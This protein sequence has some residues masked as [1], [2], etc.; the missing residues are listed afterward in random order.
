MFLSSGSGTLRDDSRRG[1]PQS[2][3]R[4]SPS[5]GSCDPSRRHIRIRDRRTRACDPR[6]LRG[7][8]CRP[9]DLSGLTAALA[10][11]E[12]VLNGQR[13][14]RVTS[15]G[16]ATQRAP[17]SRRH[18]SIPAAAWVVAI[19]LTVGACAGQGAVLTPSAPTTGATAAPAG[20]TLGSRAALQ[21]FASDLDLV[22][23]DFPASWNQ[24]EGSINP[25]GDI[26]IV[27]V[28][29]QDLPSDCRPTTGGGGDCGPWPFM[30]LDAG[31]VVV[32]WRFFGRPGGGPPTNGTPILVGTRPA[33][34][35]I[36]AADSGCSSIGGD[37]S[38]DVAV[39]ASPR[40]D[41]WIGVDACLAG[42]DHQSGE[43]AFA[44]I[45]A[46]AMIPGPEDVGPS[47]GP[48]SSTPPS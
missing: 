27:F 16:A 19:A 40:Q 35:T 7:R 20:S 38:I 28:S 1:L 22:T 42:P 41:Q 46:S 45:L 23:F 31:G 17:R 43:A 5:R 3:G 30:R 32:A 11:T 24:R 44:A 39:P 6:G 34:R 4:E 48:G 12:P 15:V 14:Y 33:L 10:R 21:H 25:S 37:E 29:P 26:P 47:E 13:R 8:R 18:R 36:G 2:D 9:R